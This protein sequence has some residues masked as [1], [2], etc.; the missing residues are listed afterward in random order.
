MIRILCDFPA[1]MNIVNI[2]K[3]L[4]EMCESVF[5]PPFDWNGKTFSEKVTAFEVNL[6][7]ELSEV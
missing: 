3:Q 4:E 6:H 1:W 7:L 5:N 2:L